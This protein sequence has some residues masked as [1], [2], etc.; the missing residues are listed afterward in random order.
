M[1]NV[2]IFKKRQKLFM[3]VPVGLPDGDQ[4]HLWVHLQQ[5]MIYYFQFRL[6]HI[7]RE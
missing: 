2:I 1:V 3:V 4:L 5:E 6:Q 7:N